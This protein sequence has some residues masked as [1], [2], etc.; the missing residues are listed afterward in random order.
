MQVSFT[1]E[2]ASQLKE[3][4]GLNGEDVH[5]PHGG[6]N[7]Y[8]LERRLDEELRIRKVLSDD[9]TPGHQTGP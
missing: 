3:D 8:V 4:L 7:R 2:F 5:N 1:P 9:E 6:G